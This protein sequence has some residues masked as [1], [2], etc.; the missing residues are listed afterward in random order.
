MKK[1]FTLI[2]LLVVI[3]IIAILAAMLLPALN[4]A[5][6]KAKAVSCVSNMKQLATGMILYANDNSNWM[7]MRYYNGSRYIYSNEVCVDLGY[8]GDGVLGCPAVQPF[9]IKS[10]SDRTS[11][12]SYR[13]FGYGV[14]SHKND[15]AKSAC[16]NATDKFL[17][18]QLDKI[19]KCESALGYSVPLLGESIHG[20]NGTSVPCFWRGNETYK[21]NLPHSA[22]MNLALSDGHV[23][24]A[25]QNKLKQS[26]TGTTGTLYLVLD[27]MVGSAITL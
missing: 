17:F 21:W 18:V 5:R 8:V 14:N 20:T 25:D 2:E 3:A 12:N 9:K 19:P 27:N 11:A 26:F 24:T 10:G 7:H 6:A 13:D 16:S 23:E 4:K 1:K 15:L 22:R